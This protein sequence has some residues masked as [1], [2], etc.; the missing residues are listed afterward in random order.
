[1]AVGD[2]F[3]LVTKFS[4][5]GQ[6]LRP[7]LH[8]QSNVAL[9]TGSDL[10]T[11]FHSSVTQVLISRLPADVLLH[12]FVAEDKVPGLAAS[13]ETTI[14]PPTPGALAEPALPPQ[15]AVL[16]SFKSALKSQ[17]SRGRVYW[18]GAT[19]AGTASGQLTSTS[20]SLWNDW[21]N[22]LL[23][24][25]VGASPVSGWRLVTYSPEDLTPPKAPPV[26]KPRP[27]QVITPVS[28]II[29][30]PVIRSQRRRQIGK[31]Q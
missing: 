6:Q 23:T 17:R 11:T 5:F 20:Q 29:L 25:Y 30:D 27:G 2:V 31:G 13:V 19:E 7:G 28:A 18:P 15:D 22:H 16:F 9:N 26:F 21:V 10:I 8:F 24:T 14:V 4:L 3:K 12:G 1:M